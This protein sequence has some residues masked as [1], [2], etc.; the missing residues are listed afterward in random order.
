[1]ALPLRDDQYISL[2]PTDSPA[3]DA[4]MDSGEA[5]LGHAEQEGSLHERRGLTR[6]PAVTPITP[7]SKGVNFQQ[8][9][10]RLRTDLPGDSSERRSFDTRA[11]F[12]VGDP[13]ARFDAA[14]PLEYE[15]TGE[16][17]HPPLGLDL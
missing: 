12:V 16:I 4:E 2:T 14:A 10:D 3:E 15:V 6:M 17:G 1:M 7:F 11:R 13:G 8:F 9:C 5:P